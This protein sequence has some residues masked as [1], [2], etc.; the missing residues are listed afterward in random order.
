MTF[1]GHILELG[2]LLGLAG[3]WK[4]L[5]APLLLLL[6]R[7]TVRI[8]L[9]AERLGGQVLV[10]TVDQSDGIGPHFERACCFPFATS[11]SF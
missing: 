3:K 7:R 10:L 4:E 1:D 6:H 8:D 11:F 9:I 2:D 5:E